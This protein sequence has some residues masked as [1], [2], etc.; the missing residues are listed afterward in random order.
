MFKREVLTRVNS[1]QVSVR[2]FIVLINSY[3]M[4]CFPLLLPLCQVCRERDIQD[5]CYYWL[6]NPCHTCHYIYIYIYISMTSE[7]VSRE[8]NV[9]GFFT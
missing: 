8:K 6:C 7:R 2:F 5:L 3:L 4:G 1:G 9:R